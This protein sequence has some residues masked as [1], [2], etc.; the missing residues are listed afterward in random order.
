MKN[1][2]TFPW[3]KP[4]AAIAIAVMATS[5][6]GALAWSPEPWRYDHDWAEDELD[7]SEVLEKAETAH[8]DRNDPEEAYRILNS[9]RA[10]LENEEVMFW[11]AWYASELGRVDEAERIYRELL[12][13][14]PDDGL[15]ELKGVLQRALNLET[16]YAKYHNALGYLLVTEGYS[17]LEEAFEH[18]EKALETSPRDPAVI[19]SYGYA[20]RKNGDL[21]GA[22][23]Q[24]GKA[25]D[26]LQSK[27]DEDKMFFDY[28]TVLLMSRP[29]KR[30]P[31]ARF[32]KSMLMSQSGEPGLSLQLLG[33]CTDSFYEDMAGLLD[34]YVRKNRSSAK[35][36]IF[37][38]LLLHQL[39]EGTD[40][41]KRLSEARQI[42]DRR[43]REGFR[44]SSGPLIDDMEIYGFAAQEMGMAREAERV[45][46][47]LVRRDRGN[48]WHYIRLGCLLAEEGR[49][50]REV[51]GALDYALGLAPDRQDILSFH[52]T[53]LSVRIARVQGNE[54]GR[55]RCW[56]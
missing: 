26:R 14:K 51:S 52:G 13:A 3:L 46:Q 41:R 23:R 21:K 33:I 39:E 18:L 53:A 28:G 11:H 10:G 55:T 5:G 8:R 36:R 54:T 2:K 56:Q 43:D 47:D 34:E 49:S 17:E 44:M 22:E 31:F 12:G 4:R 6:Q 15:S 37:H 35:A 48:P 1:D 19:H 29:G 38:A 27:F 20:L 50:L 25:L 42:I 40:A 32:V 9:R 45:Y 7:I 16:K 24:Y 30:C